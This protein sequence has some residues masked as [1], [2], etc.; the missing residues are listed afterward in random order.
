MILNYLPTFVQTTVGSIFESPQRVIIFVDG[1][2]FYHSLKKSFGSAKID[3][4]KFCS[5]VSKGKKLIAIKY[6]L[7]PLNQLDNPKNYAAQ[8]L[9]L[10]KL[11]Q[12][13]IVSVFLGR[14]EKR[15]DGGKVEK[16]IDVKLAID[17]FAGA[18]RGEFDEAI[19]IS[20]DADFV[21]AIQEVQA[22]GKKVVNVSFPKTKSYHLN[23][24]CDETIIIHSIKDFLLAK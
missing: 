8:Q 23:K 3:L 17:L 10:E 7:S 6:Y 2:N 19:L 15:P 11:K 16:G 21:P 14:L 4:L 24:I 12:L 13:K 18:V 5:F 9:F 22:L 1:S 20:N